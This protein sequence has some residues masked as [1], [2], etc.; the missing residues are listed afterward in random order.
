MIVVRF[1]FLIVV[2]VFNAVRT[3]WRTVLYDLPG[4]VTGVAP[5]LDREKGDRGAVDELKIQAKC[6]R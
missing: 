2:R 4:S 5:S 3:I 1:L 6:K